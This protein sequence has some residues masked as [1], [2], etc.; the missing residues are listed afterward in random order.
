[1]AERFFMAADIAPVAAGEG[2]LRRVL[3]HNPQLMMVQIDFEAGA[4]G[5]AHTHP[6]TQVTYIVS[7][8]FRFTNDGETREVGPGDSL[9]FAPD[10]PHGTIC[11]EAGR[12]IDVFTPQREDFL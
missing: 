7:G 3:A 4:V 8:R 9:C 10:V 11:L 6:H 2:V 12:V 1:M 5:T